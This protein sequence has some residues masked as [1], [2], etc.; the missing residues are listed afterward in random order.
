MK[1]FELYLPLKPQV[2]TQGFG[3]TANLQYYKDSGVSI[4]KHNGIDYLAQRGQPV[5]ACHDGTCYPGVDSKEGNGVVIRTDEDF[6]YEGNP[7]RFKTIYWHL[8]K[9]DAVVKTG[10]K[11]KAGDLIGYA[12]ST[13]LST[14]N[15]LHFGLKPQRWNE[16]DWIWYNVDQDNGIMGAIDPNQYFNKYYA[17]DAKN[18]E[19]VLRSIISLLEQVLL[20]LKK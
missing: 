3:S 16:N 10:Q 14:G 13:G 15:H 19:G 6:E 8:V 5:Y 4:T 9:S 17:E 20:L 11:V 18:V 12:D 7:T 1:K 2:I